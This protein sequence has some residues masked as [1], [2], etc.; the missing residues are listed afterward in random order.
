MA[1]LPYKTMLGIPEGDKYDETAME[2][3][4]TQRAIVPQGPSKEDVI[5]G[6][7]S[8]IDAGDEDGINDWMH[9]LAELGMSPTE[10]PPDL[11]AQLD[12]PDTSS[13]QIDER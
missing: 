9:D 12:A 6:L 3:N 11:Q 1:L 10:L 5:A 8:A 7:R 13:T 2:V 4:A